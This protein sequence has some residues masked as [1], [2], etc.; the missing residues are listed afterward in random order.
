LIKAVIEASPE[1]LAGERGSSAAI[2]VWV[3]V[4]VGMATA[5]ANPVDTGETP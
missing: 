4:V 2:D 5:L 3:D 1:P